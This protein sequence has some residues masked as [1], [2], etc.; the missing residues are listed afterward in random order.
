[1]DRVPFITRAGTTVASGGRMNHQEA[2][3]GQGEAGHDWCGCLGLAWTPQGCAAPG[4][5]S[6]RPEQSPGGEVTSR[7]LEGTDSQGGDGSKGLRVIW[8]SLRDQEKGFQEGE[9]GWP[10][11]RGRGAG[12]RQPLL[13][14][15]GMTRAGWG[16]CTA[17]TQGRCSLSPPL[18][19]PECP[20]VHTQPHHHLLRA[21]P[22][23]PAPRRE[24]PKAAGT[25]EGRTRP[26]GEGSLW[27]LESDPGDVSPAVT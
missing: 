23:P 27:A 6:G 14:A 8:P 12:R 17:V 7:S 18:M 22:F 4:S 26:S 16:G 3:L 24:T 19:G 15:P 5:S 13:L 9:V 25:T 11:A 1:M 2:G 20:H 10:G 21:H